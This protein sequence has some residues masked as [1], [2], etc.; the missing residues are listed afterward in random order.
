MLMA[1][2]VVCSF[3]S[4]ADYAFTAKSDCA[5]TLLTMDWRMRCLCFDWFEG[6]PADGV[7]M[8]LMRC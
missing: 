3:V 8:A 1:G 5:C 2:R 6:V 7:V 4:D